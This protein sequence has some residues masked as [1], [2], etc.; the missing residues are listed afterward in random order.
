MSPTQ[1]VL[2]ILAGGTGIPLLVFAIAHRLVE[3]HANRVADAIRAQQV[4]QEPAAERPK[5]LARR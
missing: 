3:G 5:E 2:M 1:Y 4:R